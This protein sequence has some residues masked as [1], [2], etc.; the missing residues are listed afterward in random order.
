MV[1]HPASPEPAQG[2]GPRNKSRGAS[3]R[4][5][6]WLAWSLWTLCVALAVPEDRLARIGM[7]SMRERRGTGRDAARRI[8]PRGWY[9]RAC[10]P[11]ATSERA[12]GSEGEG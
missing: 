11:A 1:G 9:T 2:P 4:V 8:Q 12:S 10:P 5:A 6:A 3:A 7:S